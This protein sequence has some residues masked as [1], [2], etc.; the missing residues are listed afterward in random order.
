MG[1]PQ[2]QIR[3]QNHKFY[4]P[5]TRTENLVELFSLEGAVFA[6]L[7]LSNSIWCSACSDSLGWTVFLLSL[8]L[9]AMQNIMY[10][11]VRQSSCS[12]NLYSLFNSD[13]IGRQCAAAD[14]I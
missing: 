2:A 9:R 4:V 5:I 1:G 10:I 3:K 11:G 8:C 14:R 6:H 7:S 13:F 12:A